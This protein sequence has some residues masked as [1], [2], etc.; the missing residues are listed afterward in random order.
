VPP[1]AR[2][3]IVAWTLYDFANSAF[4]AIVVTA[5][6]PPYYADLVVGNAEGL[7]DRWWG[8]IVSVSMI[9]VALAS[10]VLGGIADHAG[11]RKP[12][13]VGFTVLAVAVDATPDSV[14]A[15]MEE[16]D[17]RY[18]VLLADERTA[19]RLREVPQVPWGLVARGFG[20]W[21]EVGAPNPS[22]QAIP[23]TG[24][25]DRNGLVRRY[26]GPVKH[27][28]AKLDILAAL[29]EARPSGFRSE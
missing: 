17:V 27:F 12:F 8:R 25:L 28:E 6:F 1:S 10:P 13:F 24:L 18:P 14:R 3:T 15:F 11:T 16:N 23:W 26:R 20:G 21:F 29:A 4:A 19:E 2:R 9:L 22:I 7:G 5:V